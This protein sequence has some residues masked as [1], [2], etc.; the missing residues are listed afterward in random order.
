MVKDYLLW[1]KGFD[2]NAWKLYRNDFENTL[3]WRAWDHQQRKIE[4]LEQ[5]NKELKDKLKA[6]YQVIDDREKEVNE[7][8]EKLEILKALLFQ[9]SI[10]LLPYAGI[11]KI[12]KIRG[13]I[14][15]ELDFIDKIKKV[16]E[17]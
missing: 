7:L 5:E 12:D 11:A 9:I 1:L 3:S 17:W 6:I 10:Q 16:G 13:E 2:T 4:K 15:D 8:K 14:K